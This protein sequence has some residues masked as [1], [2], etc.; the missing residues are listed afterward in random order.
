MTM[1]EDLEKIINALIRQER[2]WI[3]I[4]LLI[5][6]VPFSFQKAGFYER[7]KHDIARLTLNTPGPGRSNKQGLKHLVVVPVSV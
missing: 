6:F 4:V 7:I 3:K 5:L 2:M 1:F